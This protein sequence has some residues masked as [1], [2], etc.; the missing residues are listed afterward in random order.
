MNEAMKSI[1]DKALELMPW[2]VNKTLSAADAAELEKHFG[3]CLPCRAAL[4]E[5]RRI[6]ALVCAQADLP[7]SAEHGI[8]DLMHRIDSDRQSTARLSRSPRLAYTLIGIAVAAGA[9]VLLST[10]TLFLDEPD[11]PF[12]TLTNTPA[13]ET[14]RIDIVFADDVAAAQAAEIVESVGGRILEGPSE[15]GRYSVEL[16][17]AAGTSM[18]TVIEQ[19]SEDARVRFVAQT[20]TGTPSANH[21]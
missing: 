19:L 21:Q 13:T 18:Q 15:I 20:F 2:Y 7:L 8:S 12:S 10:L 9:L 4:Q 17:G 1:H 5:E 6:Q 3:E 16:S 11:V 14:A